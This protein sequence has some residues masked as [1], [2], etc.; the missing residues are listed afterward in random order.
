MSGRSRPRVTAAA[1]RRSSAT[2]SPTIW[3]TIRSPTS[4]PRGATSPWPPRH[5]RHPPTA[6]PTAVSATLS[7]VTHGRCIASTTRATTLPACPAASPTA[8]RTRVPPEATHTTPQGLNG[9]L[10]GAETSTEI[11]RQPARPCTP[12]PTW[13][14]SKLATGTARPT[15]RYQARSQGAVPTRGSRRGAPA[16][17][18]A[19]VGM[20]GSSDVSG[21]NGTNTSELGRLEQGPCDR[22]QE[23]CRRAPSRPHHHLDQRPV[24]RSTSG[25]HPSR[26]RSGRRSRWLALRGDTSSHTKRTVPGSLADRPKKSS[27]ACRVWPLKKA[28]HRWE[29]IRGGKRG[30]QL[31][32]DDLERAAAGA[33][34]RLLKLRLLRRERAGSYR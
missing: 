15:A 6:N 19:R 32:A 21:C 5:H 23:E 27:G 12:P 20:P 9:R 18:T 13:T 3:R 10:S 29:P 26:G 30:H 22:S 28:W 14:D 31:A 25:Q 34:L 8:A 4:S 1:P 7:V 2:T 16:R 17:C 33:G 24:R 11:C